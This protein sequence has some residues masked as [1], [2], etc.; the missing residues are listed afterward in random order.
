MIIGGDYDYENSTEILS[1]T[2]GTSKPSYELQY[3]GRGACLIPDDST[4]TYILTSGSEVSRYDSVGWVESLPRMMQFRNWHGCGSYTTDSGQRILLV[5]GGW[6]IPN[7]TFLSSVETLTL[8]TEAW[9][10]APELP[11][12]LSNI[13]GASLDNKIFILGGMDRSGSTAGETGH[14]NN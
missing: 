3:S 8:G 14:R 11:R 5:A 10:F 9:N 2:D 4:S 7:F 1:L 6:D 12:A 13:A